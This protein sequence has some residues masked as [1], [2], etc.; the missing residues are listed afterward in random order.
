MQ[1]SHLKLIIFGVIFVIGLI[2]LMNSINLSNHEISNIMKANYGSMDTDKYLI[3]LEQSIMKHRVVGS[4]IAI[5]GG[6]GILAAAYQC[7][8]KIK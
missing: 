1:N 5:M 2:I 8:G 6:L 3:Y 7:A 4:I